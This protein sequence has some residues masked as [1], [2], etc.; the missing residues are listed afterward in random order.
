M[1]ERRWEK[2]DGRKETGESRR[3]KEGRRLETGERRWENGE[4]RKETGDRK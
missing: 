2:G 3:E 4:G 1:K